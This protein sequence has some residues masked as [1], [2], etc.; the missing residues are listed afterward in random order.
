[1]SQMILSQPAPAIAGRATDLGSTSTAPSVPSGTIGGQGI[2]FALVGSAGTGLQLG[3]YAFSAG[4][5]GAQVAS[6]AAWL[7]STLVTNAAHRALTFGVRGGERNRA[8]QFVA[9]LTCLVGLLITSVVLAQVPDADGTSG[10]VAILAVNT[11]VG[12]ARFGGMRWWLS[13]SGQRFGA[14]VSA[15][16]LAARHTWHQH[17]P[18][19]G[20]HH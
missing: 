7:L 8:D 10:I 1:M 3:L 4:F 12:A 2:R 18:M 9:F 11:V 20:L 5:L 6:V 19:S 15:V 17:G 13:P 14:Q 16:A